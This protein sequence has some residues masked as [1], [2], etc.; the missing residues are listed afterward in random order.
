M[1]RIMRN[2]FLQSLSIGGPAN[3]ENSLPEFSGNGVLPQIAKKHPTPGIK[4]GH[5]RDGCQR[6]VDPGERRLKL[7]EERKSE[8]SR[9]PDQ[10]RDEYVLERRTPVKQPVAVIHLLLGEHE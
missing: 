1:R 6:H 3:H 2:D 7:E 9:S 4:P 5:S 8:E 10:A